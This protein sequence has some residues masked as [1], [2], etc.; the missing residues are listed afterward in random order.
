M[1]RVNAEAISYDSASDCLDTRKVDTAS[2]VSLRDGFTGQE[3][4]L[5]DFSIGYSDF[6]ARQYSPTLSRWLVPDPM[7]EKYYDVS[8]YAYCAGNPVNR[9]DIKGK[10]DFW[11]NGQI[12]G[13]DGVHDQRALVIRTEA[14]TKEEIKETT[15]F[16]KANSGSMEAFKDND[17]A[18]RN[19]IEIESSVSNRQAMVTEISKDNGKGGTD[20]SNNREYGGSIQ[21]GR[22]VL[23]EPGPIANPKTDAIASID[24]PTGVSTFHSHPSGTIVEYPPANTIGGSTTS[25]S[26]IQQPSGIDISNAGT[27]TH[28]V[29]G[30]SS[31]NVYIYTSE[32]V[33]AI[34]P[35]KH[36]VTPKD[37]R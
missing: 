4:Q 10:A 32:G 1:I 17:I 33:Q 29:F 35:M 20:D 26:F 9:V 16:I 31:G 25:Y 21:N 6:G 5:P 36:F 28:Y 19:S 37:K 18:Y 11:L 23:A 3:D 12:I 8:P 22:I 13:D 15:G 7:G 14:L 30:R 27:N 24:L 34:I 2:A